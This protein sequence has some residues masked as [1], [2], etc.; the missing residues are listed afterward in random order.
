M[1]NLPSCWQVQ[2]D[3][4]QLFKDTVIKYLNSLSYRNKRYFGGKIKY[5]YGV[6]KQAS[7]SQTFNDF[8]SYAGVTT[9]T[10]QEF[11]QL[12][13]YNSITKTFD[14]TTSI[15]N[16]AAQEVLNTKL[17]TK[18][19]I[20]RTPDTAKVINDWFNKNCN[21]GNT[22]RF[23]N[24]DDYRSDTQSYLIY[25]R[26]D[27]KYQYKYI[28]Q[29]YIE[30]NI[31][32]FKQI[33]NMSNKPQTFV[34]A[35]NHHSHIGSM[36]ESLKDLGYIMNVG[37]MYQPC[38]IFK[39]I[40]HKDYE[41]TVQCSDIAGHTFDK[42]FNLPQDYN[43]ALDFAK[44]QLTLI[45]P[46]S[47]DYSMNCYGEDGLEILIK[48]DGSIYQ[49]GDKDKITD[50]GVI[51]DLVTERYRAFHLAKYK[52]VPTTFSIGCK[53]GITINDL[54]EIVKLYDKTFD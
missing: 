2:N 44:E 36:I 53:H 27:N 50:I 18:W 15:I 17:P 47:I 1:N 29:G 45:K 52:I 8:Y 35:S 14:T 51:K 22:I 7:I 31:N 4:S 48:A 24:C 3:G 28:P 25:P 38:I 10:I 42:Q 43:K 34:I 40:R 9:L 5:W 37:N 23:T 20:S 19:C 54:Q 39:S 26:L 12:S 16:Q 33:I 30:I 41:L 49:K 21:R 46:S 11:I 13:N 32:Q 6:K